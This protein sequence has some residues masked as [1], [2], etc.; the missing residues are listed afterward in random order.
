[1]SFT[2]TF[3]VTFFSIFQIRVALYASAAYP[4]ALRVALQQYYT[5]AEEKMLLLYMGVV[6]VHIIII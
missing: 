4:S 5:V 3:S 2:V 6:P 1:M